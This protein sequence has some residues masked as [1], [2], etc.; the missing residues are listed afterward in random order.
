[1]K[2][3]FISQPY[4]YNPEDAYERAKVYTR[5][6]VANARIP[7]SPILMFHWTYNNS[8]YQ[9]IIYNCFQLIRLCDKL[10]V[11]EL[12]TIKSSGMD[13]EIAYATTLN[14]PI[15]YVEL[16]EEEYEHYK[17]TFIENKS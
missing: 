15:T 4:S 1:M 2:L 10:W 8:N 11:F 14:K 6:V 12:P 7:V 3:I 17:N 16:T 13:C 5:Y 9:Q